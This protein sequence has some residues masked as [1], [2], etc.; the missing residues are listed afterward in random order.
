MNFYTPQATYSDTNANSFFETSF[1]NNYSPVV[2]AQENQ[3]VTPQVATRGPAADQPEQPDPSDLAYDDFKSAVVALG[4]RNRPYNL[5]WEKNAGQLQ[6][7]VQQ[8][9]LQSVDHTCTALLFDFISNQREEIN[10][11]KN[12]V[13]SVGKSMLDQKASEES[14]RKKEAKRVERAAAAAEKKQEAKRIERAAAAAERKKQKKE[15]PVVPPPPPPSPLTPPSS[16]LLPP[17]KLTL[18]KANKRPNVDK[19]NA[20]V[21]VEK[22]SKKNK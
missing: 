22:K 19:L 9:Q 20:R 8:A 2:Y 6:S 3:L 17:L 7:A 4:L 14:S 15:R 10:F 11:L 13:Y 18:G 21:S 1:S 16:P 12:V 5:V